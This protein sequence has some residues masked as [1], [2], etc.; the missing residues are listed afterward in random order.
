MSAYIPMSNSPSEG[1]IY[2]KIY[3]A[4]H[5]HRKSVRLVLPGPLTT[6]RIVWERAASVVPSISQLFASSRDHQLPVRAVWASQAAGV[7]IF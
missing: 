4:A 6:H 7:P 5:C 2:S 1:T 3:A